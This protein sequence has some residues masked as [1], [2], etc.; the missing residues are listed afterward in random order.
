[1]YVISLIPFKPTSAAQ[2]C[3]MLP[4]NQAAGLGYMEH[5]NVYSYT[6]LN[7]FTEDTV[8][9]ICTMR[10]NVSI[11]MGVLC[12]YYVL[13]LQLLES[14]ESLMFISSSQDQRCIGQDFL[15]Y[16]M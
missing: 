3:I 14:R 4:S 1:M 13:K 16:A 5:G 10:T 12:E 11:T 9:P 6:V 15:K 7:Y 8:L 2:R